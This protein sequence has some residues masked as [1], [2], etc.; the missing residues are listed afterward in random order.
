MAD[1]APAVRETEI[2][3]Q[4]WH[5]ALEEYGFGQA[6]RARGCLIEEKGLVVASIGLPLLDCLWA[7]PLP[8]YRHARHVVGR[9]DGEKKNEGQEVDTDQY[10]DPVH[11]PS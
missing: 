6:L 11:E 5:R 2:Q 9:V 8:A 10:E 7:Y 3:H 4:Q 1:T